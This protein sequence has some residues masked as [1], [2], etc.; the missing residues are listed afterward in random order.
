[1]YLILNPHTEKQL[2]NWRQQLLYSL[3]KKIFFFPCILSSR[4]VPLNPQVRFS[5]VSRSSLEKGWELIAVCLAMFPPSTK[6]HSYLEG[7]VDSHLKDNQKPVNKILE[8]EISVSNSSLSTRYYCKLSTDFL[9]VAYQNLLSTGVLQVVSTSCN[10][11]DF[12]DL[13][14]LDEIDKFVSTSW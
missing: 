5:I 12:T 13:L 2:K 9:L 1:M 3:S 11:P 7:Y 8:Q 14:Q 10:K 6:Y 4:S